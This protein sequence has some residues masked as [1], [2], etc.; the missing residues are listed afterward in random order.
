MPQMTS[1]TAYVPELEAKAIKKAFSAAVINLG[2]E[3]LARRDL[4][5]EESGSTMVACFIRGN[6]LF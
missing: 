5:I 4:E 3:I 1:T 6:L 2:N